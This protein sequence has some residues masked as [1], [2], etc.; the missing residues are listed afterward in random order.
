MGLVNLY[1]FLL[2]NQV[3]ECNFKS[4]LKNLSLV[5]RNAVLDV[6][7]EVLWA[8]FEPCRN[9]SVSKSDEIEVST[10]FVKQKESEIND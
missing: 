9:C 7:L 2:H 4:Y 6:S 8:V 3:E 5:A 10:K 1:C